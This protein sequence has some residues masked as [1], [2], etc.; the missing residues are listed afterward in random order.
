V[1]DGGEHDG[2][3]AAGA[4]DVG[5]ADGAGFG[6]PQRDEQPAGAQPHR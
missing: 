5:Q 6:Q 1:A 2:V 4:V 3:E